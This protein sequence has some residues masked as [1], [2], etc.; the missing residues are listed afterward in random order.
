MY[1]DLQV[2][3]GH[4]VLSDPG[5][6]CGHVDVNLVESWTEEDPGRFPPVIRRHQR[7]IRVVVAGWSSRSRRGPQPRAKPIAG[8][9]VGPDLAPRAVPPFHLFEDDTIGTTNSRHRSIMLVRTRNS[10]R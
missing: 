5:R 3:H 10:T 8:D 1:V 7:E 6:R 4:V 2:D 9:A